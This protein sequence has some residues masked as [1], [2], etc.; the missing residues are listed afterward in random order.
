MSKVP[1]SHRLAAGKA[2][3]QDDFPESARI[4]LLH[5]LH[6]LVEQRFIRGWIAVDK[7][8]R[9]IARDEPREYNE[10]KVQEVNAARLSVRTTLN[11]LQWTAAL[12][13]C[14]RIHSRLAVD[15]TDWRGP[16]DDTQVVVT[17]RE[18]VQLYIADELERIFLEE[19]LAFT[20]V[21]NEIRA[22]GRKHTRAQLAKAEPT[23]ADP[24]LSEARQYFAKA[25]RYFE[26][27]DS[28]DFENVIKEAVCA[29][30][31]AAKRLFPES[32]GKP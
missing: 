25:M 30:E 16:N 6:D 1:I 21:E 15:V 7:E 18:K 24:R 14:E 11:S 4:A 20:F 9:R 13:F 17:P 28:P 8:I 22:R 2:W 10:S 26:N 12:D 32:K 3:I 27:K 19:H 23:F 5:L 31:A 29:V